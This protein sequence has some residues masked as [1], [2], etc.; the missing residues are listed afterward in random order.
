MAIESKRLAEFPIFRDLPSDLLNDLGRKVR[1]RSL[2]PGEELCRQGE[3]GDSLFLIESGLIEIWLDSPLGRALGR[4]ARRNEALGEASLLTGEPRSATLVAAVPTAI[5]EVDRPTFG[6]LV[7]RH[8]DLLVNIASMLVGRQRII[9]D[10]QRSD[11]AR[12]E[13]IAL[14]VDDDCR[15]LASSVLRATCAASVQP[16][17]VIDLCGSL[18]VPSLPREGQAISSA[19]NALD[20]A[21]AEHRTVLTVVR[22]G[23]PE[24]PLLVRSVDRV[25]ALARAQRVGSVAS[26]AHEGLRLELFLIGGPGDR[27][28]LDRL[29]VQVLGSAVETPSVRDVNWLGRHL[30]RTKIGLA[31]GAGGAKCYAH[32]GFIEAL[33][34]AGFPVDYVAGTSMGA[35]V[36]ACLAMGKSAVQTTEATARILSPEICG[37]YFKLA[38]DPAGEGPQIFWNALSQLA[39]GLSFAD[40]PVPLAIMTADLRSRSPHLFVDGSVAG[41][42]RATL[43][44]PGLAQPY[45][46]G[47]LRLIDGVTISPVPTQA[48]RDLGADITVAVNLLSRDELDKWPAELAVDLPRKKASEPIDVMLETLMMLQLDTST[49][50]TAE[51]DVAVTPR[52]ARAS[53]RDIHLLHCFEHAGREAAAASLPA[54]RRLCAPADGVKAAGGHG[55]KSANAWA[56][57]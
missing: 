41:A 14:V 50:Q 32:I 46:R 49:R 27:T 34:T 25:V 2:Q 35:V 22:A 11:T 18:S 53:W 48:V 52:F 47:D 13:A 54:L 9:D 3:R 17:G 57:R 10:S 56:T 23:D 6:D 20:R 45:E 28:A 12:S 16:V 33:E 38:P 26:L 19:L 31:L 1:R 4:R 29:P 36:A 44:I 15:E 8:P 24:L 40:L 37:P 30:A 43:T 55:S 51:A 5:L 7:Q 21:L 39:A 42:L